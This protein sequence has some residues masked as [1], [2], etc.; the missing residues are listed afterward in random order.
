MQ[1]MM[2]LNDMPKNLPKIK[3]ME[4]AQLLY[5]LVN[6]SERCFCLLANQARPPVTE[7]IFIPDYDLKS[8]LWLATHTKGFCTVYPPDILGTVFKDLGQNDECQEIAQIYM[9]KHCP[10]NLPEKLLEEDPTDPDCFFW[11]NRIATQVY[12]N[13]HLFFINTPTER[14]NLYA[15]CRFACQSLYFGLMA[16]DYDPGPYPLFI[17]LINKSRAFRLYHEIWP[18]ICGCHVTVL[19]EYGN[20]NELEALKSLPPE[21][22]DQAALWAAEFKEYFHI[23]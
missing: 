7:A 11:V 3:G 17:D 18:L 4:K 5:D 2:I 23:L 8:L 19:R 21:T 9:R 13:F 14:N 16:Q 1:D 12:K 15:F 10:E 22:L 6:E 20:K